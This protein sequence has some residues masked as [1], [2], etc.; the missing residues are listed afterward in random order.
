ME[1]FP[2]HNQYLYVH[3]ELSHSF[4]LEDFSQLKCYKM[5]AHFF[6]F[7]QFIAL[8]PLSCRFLVSSKQ[9]RQQP[10]SL[11]IVQE[12]S[13]LLPCLRLSPSS[14]QMFP[15][16]HLFELNVITSL[17]KQL[18]FVSYD[19]YNRQTKK[20]TVKGPQQAI[21]PDQAS[22]HDTCRNCYLF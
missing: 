12:Q 10:H 9:I 2:G 17:Q 18:I 4:N 3:M 7:S 6:F 1:I 21:R 20:T 19:N 16:T 11:W 22:K 5:L 14:Y 13:H 8:S 15:A